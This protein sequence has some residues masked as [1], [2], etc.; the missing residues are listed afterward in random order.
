MAGKEKVTNKKQNTLKGGKKGSE[1]KKGK[2]H[3]V[4]GMLLLK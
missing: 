2:G 1:V 3:N 4:A